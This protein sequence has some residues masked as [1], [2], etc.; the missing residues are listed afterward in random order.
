[1]PACTA[2]ATSTRAYPVRPDVGAA[3]A[4]SLQE[5]STATAGVPRSVPSSL[6][7]HGLLFAFVGVQSVV[8]R[9]SHGAGSEPF[10]PR[11]LRRGAASEIRRTGTALVGIAGV[12]RHRRLLDDDGSMLDRP[13]TDRRCARTVLAGRSAVSKLEEHLADYT[14]LRRSL[15]YVGQRVQRLARLLRRLHGAIWSDNHIT[16]EQA[17]ASGQ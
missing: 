16:T 2:R 11:R 17:L 7:R 8:R 1:M 12:I 10:G 14:I 6:G 13:S 15:G 3:M 9:E 5:R 4:G